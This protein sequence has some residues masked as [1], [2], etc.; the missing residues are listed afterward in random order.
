MAEKRH[1][2][3]P[4]PKLISKKL[5]LTIPRRIYEQLKKERQLYSYVS[6]QQLIIDI[7]RDRYLKALKKSKRGRPKKID[8]SKIITREKIFDKDGEKIEI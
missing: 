8:V 3:V 1:L 6:N 4:D 7:L 2:E 5:I